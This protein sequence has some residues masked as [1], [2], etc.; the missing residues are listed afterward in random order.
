MKN[1]ANFRFRRV[2][3]YIMT[4]VTTLSTVGLA[5]CFVIL[6]VLS[7]LFQEV[8]QKEAFS[9]DTATLL[10]IHES[11]SPGL[12]QLMLVITHLGNPEVVV[13]IFG[14][15]MLW[16]WWKH[17]QLEAK[18]LAIACFGA[19]V[20]NWGL[21]LFFAKPRPNLWP[22]LITE[23]S[24]SFPSGHALGSLVFY[25]F[26]SYILANQFQRAAVSIHSM[27]IVL[28][29]A[30][31]YSRLYL[32]VHWPTDIISGYGVGFLWLTT[33]ITLL[34]ILFQSASKEGSTQYHQRHGEKTVR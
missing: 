8:W 10:K 3:S 31:G 27:A 15:T 30:I 14:G 4:F 1:L 16:L 5:I 29:A 11:A 12:D 32:G 34:K 6:V 23:T 22:Q 9:F 24:F 7:W 26:L 13:G 18:M 28:I 21:K 19:V 2:S 17:R 25:G 33:C 20:L